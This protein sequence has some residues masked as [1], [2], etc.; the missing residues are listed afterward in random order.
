MILSQEAPKTEGREEALSGR[1]KTLLLEHGAGSHSFPF[2]A[3]E[4]L[5]Q[6][7]V[8]V[9]VKGWMVISLSL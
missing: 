2:Q 6:L 8:G 7:W 9:G 1:D 3:E 5:G 4:A